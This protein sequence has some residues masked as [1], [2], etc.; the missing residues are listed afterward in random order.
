[1]KKKTP[2][3]QLPADMEKIGKWRKLSKRHVCQLAEQ[4]ISYEFN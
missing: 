3:L 4:E 2:T 1:M